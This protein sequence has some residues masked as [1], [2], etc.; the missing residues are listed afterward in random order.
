[1]A[2]DYP[3]RAIIIGG[4]IVFDFDSTAATVIALAFGAGRG[5][6]SPRPLDFLVRLLR[7][8]RGRMCT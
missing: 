6:R 1:V 5:S 7:A 8:R 4:P 2:L 3:L